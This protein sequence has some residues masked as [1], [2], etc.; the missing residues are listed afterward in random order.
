MTN[1]R[2]AWPNG[3]AGGTRD[4]TGR[5]PGPYYVNTGAKPWVGSPGWSSPDVDYRAV[6]GGVLAIQ[7]ALVRLGLFTN[8]PIGLYGA[9]TERAVLKFQQS[10]PAS[11]GITPWGGVGRDTSKALFLP[12]MKEIVTQ[13][14]WRV[15]C[16]IIENESNWDPGAVGYVDPTDLGL[17]QINGPSHPSLDERER[18]DPAVAFGFVQTY[19]VE[20][21]DYLNDNL[22][23]AVA[24]Y[25]LGLGGAD[26]WI[27]AGRPDVW[28]GR[29]V[30][31][32]I[33]RILSA[34]K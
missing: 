29:E 11:A 31:A 27:A 32:Y 6:H 22:R 9:E 15:V 2:S 5:L 16:G 13:I 14:D 7:K 25:N 28:N 23:D 20:A 8:K 19:I 24:S 17:A 10:L 26:Q 30:K 4:T 12:W 21:L 34:C 33:D 1:S 18:L 3:G